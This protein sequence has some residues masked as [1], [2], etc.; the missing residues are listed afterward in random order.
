LF[1]NGSAIGLDQARSFPTLRQTF[2][3][4]PENKF[5]KTGFFSLA[6]VDIR[7]NKIGD[8]TCRPTCRITVARKHFHN[9]SH[10]FGG[11]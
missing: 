2:S 7:A 1:R 3:K 5:P 10:V 11:L 4:R 9:G 8:Q 6:E